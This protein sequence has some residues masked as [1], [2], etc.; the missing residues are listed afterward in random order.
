[1]GRSTEIVA[2]R[3]VYGRDDGLAW[4]SFPFQAHAATWHIGAYDFHAAQAGLPSYAVDSGHP[5]LG[6]DAKLG[7]AE[8]WTPGQADA[9]AYLLG[10]A[11]DS[12]AAATALA[13]GWKTDW[14]NIAWAPGDPPGG[15]QPSV[16]EYFRAR[17]GASVGVA[18]TVPI[19][20]ATPAGFLAHATGRGDYDAVAA[21]ILDVARPDVL[22]GGGHPGWSATWLDTG[23]LQDIRK[24]P[25]WTVVERAEGIA[26]GPVLAQAARDLPPGRGLLGLFGGTDGALETARPV[27]APGHPTF[28]RGVEDPASPEIVDAALTVLSR[29]PRGFFLM[30]EQGEVDWANHANDLPRAI[31]AVAS[32]DSAV[33]AA[34]AWIERPGDGLDASNTLVIVTADHATGLPRFPST[35]FLQPG[36]VPS[37]SEDDPSSWRYAGGTVGYLATSHANELVTV[38]AWGDRAGEVLEPFAGRERPGTRILEN[39]SLFE[40]ILRFAG[41]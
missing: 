9:P 19:V 22:V 20:H 16:T 10:V 39:T 17:L 38:A 1:M 8:P 21:E 30:F 24:S 5:D 25:W 31:G 33:R 7:G 3:Y 12:G 26:A 23:N 29:N 37:R 4:Q 36:E 32:L 2:S 34:I 35:G 40:A 18:T 27:N 28:E 13:T 11:T 14:G 15:A 6:Y 41:L